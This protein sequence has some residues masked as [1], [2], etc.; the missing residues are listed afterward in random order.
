MKNLR[1]ASWFGQNP[2]PKQHFP[3]VTQ[4]STYP[5]APPLPLLRMPQNW[6]CQWL[7]TVPFQAGSSSSESEGNH[8]LLL[9]LPLFPYWQALCKQ[10]QQSCC[11]ASESEELAIRGSVLP[12][13][14]AQI[15]FCLRVLCCAG[16]ILLRGLAAQP[17]GAAEA[18]RRLSWKSEVQM[19]SPALT[20]EP[21]RVLAKVCI[22][23]SSYTGIKAAWWHVPA[24]LAERPHCHRAF[25]DLLSIRDNRSGHEFVLLM[26]LMMYAGNGGNVCHPVPNQAGK[27][28]SHTP[29]FT[30]KPKHRPSDTESGC[31]PLLSWWPKTKNTD[32]LNQFLLAPSSF[33]HLSTGGIELL[34]RAPDFESRAWL[35]QQPQGAPGKS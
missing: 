6:R 28:D 26:L 22:L 14:W 2:H 34:E 23:L 25:Q 15:Q 10:A 29:C 3:Q 33:S 7:G 18:Q 13:H 16:S 12:S 32:R 8:W 17:A 27:T 5:H 35:L 31:L 1:K 30:P 9:H 4:S 19:G 21:S 20:L 24:S 11:F